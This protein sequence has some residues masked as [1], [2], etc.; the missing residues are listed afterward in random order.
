MGGTSV[1]G[2]NFGVQNSTSTT[3]PDPNAYNY[4]LAGLSM[5]SNLAGIPYEPYTGPTVAGFSQDQL[6]AMQGV[7]E[8][9]GMV[10]PY[11]DQATQLAARA[12]DLSSPSNFSQAA[13]NQYFNPLMNEFIKNAPTTYSQ[14]AVSQYY[15]PRLQAY[16]NN[17]PLNYSAEAVNQY[18]NPYQQQVIDATRA[19]IEQQ[20]AQQMSQQQAD[21]I[22]AGA[23]GGDR[24][25]A[26]R[27]QLAGQQSLAQNTTLGNLRQQ[28]Y[29]N[30]LNA[31]MA[32][33]QQALG[34]A[35]QQQ[36]SAQSMFGTQQAAGLN[37][38]Q[39]TY[40]QALAQYN[41]QQAQAIQAAQNASLAVSQL[42]GQKQQAA[43]QGYQAL[44]G[45]GQLQQQ[46]VQRQYDQNANQWYAAQG[47]PYNRVAAYLSA[48]GLAPGMGGTT[49]TNS[50]G[51]GTS[52]QQN[53][54]GNPFSQAIGAATSLFG[55]FNLSDERAKTNIDYVGEDPNTGDKL[56]AYD[57]KSDV[58]RSE[59]NGEPMP[60][61]RVSP[62]AQE[63]AEKNPDDV[64]D[65]GGLLGV[66]LGREGRANGG[67]S[68]SYGLET[69]NLPPIYLDTGEMAT[70][71]QYADLSRVAYN[72][73]PN[74]S[75][76]K[77]SG[78]S[79]LFTPSEQR[80]KIKSRWVSPDIEEKEL[81]LKPFESGYLD[82]EDREEK[83]S[84]G[85]AYDQALQNLVKENAVPNLKTDW[86]KTHDLGYIPGLPALPG[87]PMDIKAGRNDQINDIA[88]GVGKIGAK[89]LKKPKGASAIGASPAVEAENT[90]PAP[91][92]KASSDIGGGITLGGIGDYLKN[93]FN[94]GG[95]VGR[96]DGGG[97]PGFGNVTGSQLGPVGSPYT[98]GLINNVPAGVGAFNRP[99]NTGV[100]VQEAFGPRGLG[101]DI[102]QSL[103]NFRMPWSNVNTGSTSYNN[104][105][106]KAA[107]G[108]G[109]RQLTP[110]EFGFSGITPVNYADKSSTAT[111]SVPTQAQIDAEGNPV[112]KAN[113][114]NQLDL[115]NLKAKYPNLFTTPTNY[116][117]QATNWLTPEGNYFMVPVSGYGTAPFYV[118]PF[119]KGAPTYKADGGAVHRARGGSVSERYPLSAQYLDEPAQDFGGLDQGIYPAVREVAFGNPQ[120]GMQVMQ[121]KTLGFGPVEMSHG[122]RTGYATLGGVDGTSDDFEKDVNQTIRFEGRGLV[123]DD[124]G[125]GPSKFG[126]NK[127]ANPDVDVENLDEGTARRLYKE[128]YWDKIGA[129]ELP[130]NIRPM[131]YDTSVLMGPGRAKEFL[132][133]SGGD[134]EKF[135]GM[136]RSFLH[137]LV[138][139]NPVKYGKYARSWENRNNELMGSG[140]VAM[141]S[142]PA[143]VVAR[144]RGD[145][146][147]GDS[148]PIVSA[149]NDGDML[150]PVR[151]AL[152]GDRETEPGLFGFKPLINRD[153]AMYLMATGAGMAAS[154][155]RS[156]L[157]AFGEGSLQGIE[158]LQASRAG[159]SS[160]DLH[161]MQMKNLQS[162]IARRNAETEE[163]IRKIA[164]R[165]RL[166]GG[167][168]PGGGPISSDTSV[169][170]PTTAA[171]TVDV[172]E[173]PKIVEEE[174][175]QPKSLMEKTAEAEKPGVEP[176]APATPKAAPSADPI[177]TEIA[178]ASS[179][180]KKFNLMAQRLLAEGL[181]AEAAK[182]EK[183]ATDA[184]NNRKTLM[185]EKRKSLTEKVDESSPLGV[186]RKATSDDTSEFKSTLDEARS[187]IENNTVKF[188]PMAPTIA[189]GKTL[190]KELSQEFLPEEW[191]PDIDT[192]AATLVERLGAIGKEATIE[193]LGGKLGA[194]VSNADVT[195][196][197]DTD[198]N[199]A[200]SREY[201]MAILAKKE[202]LL[203]KKEAI[204]EEA[205]RYKQQ[206]GL[207]ANFAD[208]MAEWGKKHPIQSFMRKEAERKVGD[209]GKS[210]EPVSKDRTIV[211]RGKLD[212]RPVVQY[213]DGTTEYAD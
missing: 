10:N 208:H 99:V 2:T 140:P 3:T 21:A 176:A 24:T 40:A 115:V 34:I 20:N 88:K 194:G 198:F 119:A 112:T 185:Q 123:R 26:A 110:Q 46:Q 162:E 204:K 126:I 31:F 107:K 53:S 38:R 174:A 98:S 54:G 159:R 125:A 79:A 120:P 68:S 131:A 85:T 36:Q 182:F 143:G 65:L 165:K 137:N 167:T 104:L 158:A 186:Y 29:Q 168:P 189:K 28:G 192:S 209:I 187:I 61:K 105:L 73:D 207:N 33:Q 135:M 100:T 203:A 113:L 39:Q 16:L 121:E 92:D 12:Y 86:P 178:R 144:D 69:I 9:P 160:D 172:P 157:Q 155:S 84:G 181:D 177:D 27:A 141:A 78:L 136:R 71:S 139:Q 14:Q 109:P 173:A 114:Q 93:I 45:T 35:Q 212:G 117:Y 52:N 66:K 11:I 37:A 83:A 55:A 60:P 51:Y 180:E 171:P 42:G 97:L 32:Q 50:V 17:A 206:Y 127:R 101:R 94:E 134:P 67:P 108:V 49:N 5:A 184:Q 63:V 57:Y 193:K 175:T 138:E 205:L 195:F 152:G 190:T 161:A 48:A 7:R 30:A 111:T 129:S 149:S 197:M 128:R 91:T 191:Q 72:A 163:L 58:A 199:P 146:T 150:Q 118:N 18:Y 213:S 201:N 4:Y 76:V 202:A 124:A 74:L 170:T 148:S 151:H 25:G 47:S 154:R 122:G 200:K 70:P 211:K 89:Y 183:L 62:M 82:E 164:A 13:V 132:Q 153:L 19:Q 1:A 188:G 22:R 103:A 106:L 133:A 81:E 41:Q 156:P 77:P 130:E 196:M 102:P 23:F 43:L 210:S 59:E 56:Y 95:R 75:T 169:A 64:V 147:S 44:L 116:T 15:D 96:A 90:T 8:I 87:G 6:A 166:L 179:D 142:A 145:D 80:E